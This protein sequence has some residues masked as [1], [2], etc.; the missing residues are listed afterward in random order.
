MNVWRGMPVS[1]TG[2]AGGPGWSG[3]RPGV[4]S[5][6]VI[7]VRYRIIHGMPFFFFGRAVRMVVVWCNYTPTVLV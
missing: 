4:V 2:L 5:D 7:F 3:P 1:P 6:G